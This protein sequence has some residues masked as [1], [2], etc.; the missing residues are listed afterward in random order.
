MRKTAK[1]RGYVLER[2]V[3]SGDWWAKIKRRMVRAGRE[4]RFIDSSLT[5]H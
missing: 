4:Q 2:T 3:E 1:L 5:L